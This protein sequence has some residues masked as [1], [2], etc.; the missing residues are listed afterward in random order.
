[1]DYN[2]CE[3]QDQCEAIRD[4]GNNDY[5]EENCML[6]CYDSCE[7]WSSHQEAQRQNDNSNLNRKLDGY[8]QNTNYNNQNPYSQY[9]FDREYNILRDREVRYT[10]T[11]LFHNLIHQLSLY[12][13][14]IP[15]AY[16]KENKQIFGAQGEGCQNNFGEYLVELNDYLDIM[17]EWQLERFNTYVE[18]CKECMSRVYEEVWVDSDLQEKYQQE[19][20]DIEAFFL[21]SE[22]LDSCLEVNTCRYYE[23]IEYVD[24]YSQWFEC[25][26][27]EVS[28]GLEAY[29]GPHC[30]EDG[31]V[32]TL[33]VYSDEDCSE[34]I[35]DGVDVSKFIGQNIQGDELK[36]YYNSAY[37][38]SLTQ[39]EFVNEDAVCI[40]CSTTVS[41]CVF[42]IIAMAIAILPL[43][44]EY[45]LF[46]LTL[47]AIATNVGYYHVDPE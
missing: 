22:V 9:V 17:K 6:A 15:P 42:H 11:L 36:D 5:N 12:I 31:S 2:K 4:N 18:Y 44:T 46:F 40:P 10:L 3:C 20:Q 21:S 7:V 14:S 28:E 29:V 47:I 26:A 27:V 35:G 30:G 37:G 32:I 34:Y 8:Y 45:T 25:T 23:N 1:M 24:D 41:M 33:G 16:F 43:L 19:W 39:L 13:P 38:A